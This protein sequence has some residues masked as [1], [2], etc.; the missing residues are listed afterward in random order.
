M[1]EEFVR[2]SDLIFCGQNVPAANAWLLEFSQRSDL[3]EVILSIIE[4]PEYGLAPLFFAVKICH[5]AI[6][7]HW[8]NL[9]SNAQS[10]IFQV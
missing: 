6:Q 3:W 5:R 7:L 8:T 9:D 2:C 4:N 1:I 10:Y